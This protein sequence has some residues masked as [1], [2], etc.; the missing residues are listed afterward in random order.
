MIGVY[1]VFVWQRLT[2]DCK[3]WSGRI[4]KAEVPDFSLSD[5]YESVTK[6]EKKKIKN[7]QKNKNQKKKKK[8]KKMIARTIS[9]SIVPGDSIVHVL[10]KG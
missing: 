7:K 4:T 2:R 6:G 10:G 5:F 1:Y 3:S 9:C 8:K